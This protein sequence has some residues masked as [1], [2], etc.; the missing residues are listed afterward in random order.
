MVRKGG[1]TIVSTS[2][3]SVSASS[4]APARSWRPRRSGAGPAARRATASTSPATRF[5]AKI[6][7]HSETARITAPY[8]GPTTLPSSW[9]AP[10]TPSGTP[11]RAGGYRSATSARVAGTRPPPP[12]PWRNR[13]VTML[14]RSYAAAVT[15]EPRAKTTSDPTSTGSRPRRSATRP[16]SGSIAT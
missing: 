16:I 14:G 1:C 6:A 4:A 8:S 5:S 11:R 13:P 12:T 10:T 2:A 9:T 3:T 7:S 15:S